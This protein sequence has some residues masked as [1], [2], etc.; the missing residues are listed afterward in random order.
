M[1]IVGFFRRIDWSDPMM[2][3]RTLGIGIIALV[4]IVALAAPVLTWND[5]IRSGIVVLEGPTSGYW[6]GTDDLGRDVYSRTVYG[7]RVSLVIGIGA[8]CVACT[9]GIPIGICA[10]YLGGKIDMA[11]VQVIDLF[12][13]MPALILALIITAMIGPTV[14]NLV[15][16]L[17]FVMWP[18]MARIVRGQVLALRETVF[19]EAA[20]ALGGSAGWIML[21]H[22]WPNIARIVAAEFSITVSFAIF[23]SASLSF[24]GLG[25]PPPSPD[26]G[27]MVRDGFQ[28]L[29][30]NPAM[31]LG[32]GS[33]VAFTVLG[34][35]LVGSSVR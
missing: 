29:V 16:V 4:A 8:A 34:F 18:T 23:T 15:L 2:P 26:W 30:L 27:G 6:F 33:A 24:L 14:L 20:R 12:V 9:I 13:A 3:R 32:P 10:G 11:L 25:L 21:R 7:S 35:Y 28:Y 19:V 5:P 17:G 22:I 31:S 1:F